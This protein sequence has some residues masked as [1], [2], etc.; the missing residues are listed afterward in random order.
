MFA[1]LSWPASTHWPEP[2]ASFVRMSSLCR[3]S[4]GR[5]ELVIGEPALDDVNTH[6]HGCFCVIL[7]GVIIDG[8]DVVHD[9][10]QPVVADADLLAEALEALGN[11]V[12]EHLAAI[13]G[14]LVVEGRIADR[15]DDGEPSA[16]GCSTFV[17][18]KSSSLPVSVGTYHMWSYV[19]KPR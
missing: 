5:M 6:A 17:A 14:R 1:P 2:M 7:I 11:V 8:D 13:D 3:I 9:V 4:F 18:R 12:G 16:S 10:V 15:R 19:V